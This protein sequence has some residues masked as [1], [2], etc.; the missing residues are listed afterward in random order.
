MGI[1]KSYL[2]DRKR[3]FFL[4][5]GVTSIYII[6]FYLYAVDLEPVVYG[7]LLSALAG[8]VTTGRDFWQ[9]RRKH[10]ALTSLAS[11]L[12]HS[13]ESLHASDS[14]HQLSTSFDLIESDYQ[15]IFRILW[16]RAE[17]VKE[18]A[19]K[20]L[21]EIK[22]DY[23]MWVHQIKAPISAMNMIIQDSDR[24]REL[25]IEL[26]RIEQYVEMAL[27]FWRLEQT[28]AD[29]RLEEFNLLSAIKQAV[30]R[31]SIF[32][33]YKGIRL[34]LDE[35][36]CNI[37]IITDEKWLVFVVEQILSNALKY[38]SKGTIYIRMDEMSARKGGKVLIIQDTGIGIEPSDIPRL[39]EKGF[40]GYNGNL[41]KSST[42]IGL[43]LCKRILEKLTHKI[44]LQSEPEIGTTVLI[45]LSLD[46]VLLD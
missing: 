1:F 23:T 46:E 10:R 17:K 36:A 14:D 7:T 25:A 29:L 41:Q 28:T 30:R 43:Y 16:N 40:T 5:G 39:F 4:V 13:L 9:Y 24:K 22:E 37:S 45:D 44:S 15:N 8:A 20:Q 6:V 34:E 12:S 33:I 21:L 11:H 42:G 2:R 31:F 32:F 3:V 26:L 18:D 19:D 38:T 35:E 27:A